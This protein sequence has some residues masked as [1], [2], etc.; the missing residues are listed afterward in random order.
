MIVAIG[1]PSAPLAV[2]GAVIAGRGRSPAIVRTVVV[3][4][5]AF[6]IPVPSS[7]VH[8]MLYLPAVPNAGVPVIVAVRGD[9]PA[10]CAVNVSDAGFPAWV[11]VSV[12]QSG[13]VAVA[14][15]VA[16]AVPSVPLAVAGAVI[17]GCWLLLAMVRTVVVLAD[18][19]PSLTVHRML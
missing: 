10:A 14:V 18:V 1:Q 11:I 6:V 7:T 19:I 13:S 4:A 3:L 15:I 8:T 9:G 2:A 12:P 16:I 5:V 17:A